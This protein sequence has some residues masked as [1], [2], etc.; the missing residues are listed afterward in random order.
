MKGKKQGLQSISL[1]YPTFSKIKIKATQSFKIKFFL[2]LNIVLVTGGNGH[3][4]QHITQQLLSLQVLPS[5]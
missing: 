2:P 4:A 5:A 3:V 1:K